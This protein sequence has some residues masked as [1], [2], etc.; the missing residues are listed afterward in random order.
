LHPAS[1]G[2]R[3]RSVRAKLFLFSHLSQDSPTGK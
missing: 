2:W 1:E 3:N